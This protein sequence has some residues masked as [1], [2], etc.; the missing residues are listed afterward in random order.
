M[1]DKD[2][3]LIWENYKS[4]LQEGTD[5]STS[6]LTDHEK[7]KLAAGAAEQGKGPLAVNKPDDDKVKAEASRGSDD[8]DA[9]KLT[10]DDLE[11]AESEYEGVRLSKFVDEHRSDLDKQQP[12]VLQGW[13]LVKHYGK[14][15]AQQTSKVPGDS[16]EDA[17]RGTGVISIDRA[18]ADEQRPGAQRAFIVSD[19]KVDLDEYKQVR[20]AR[21]HQAKDMA[22]WRHD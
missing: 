9:F 20:A 5:G 19:F 6:D 13:D 7:L 3:K 22:R 17:I 21:G 18:V 10:A 11:Q 8:P 15:H 12:V 1:Q 4:N 16:I 2:Q 14:V